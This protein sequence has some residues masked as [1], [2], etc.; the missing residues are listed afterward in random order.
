M[1]RYNLAKDCSRR[2]TSSIKQAL[3]QALF[4]LSSV[5]LTLDWLAVNK[6]KCD[7]IGNLHTGTDLDGQEGTKDSR[8]SRRDVAAADC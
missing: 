3:R 8:E 5:R 6:G 2:G 7:G 4:A 1:F